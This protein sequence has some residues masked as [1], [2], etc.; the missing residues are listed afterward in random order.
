M[1]ETDLNLRRFA[2]KQLALQAPDGVLADLNWDELHDLE[3]SL[4]N[5]VKAVQARKSLFLETTDFDLIVKAES[6][7]KLNIMSVNLDTSKGGSV[8]GSPD[9]KLRALWDSVVLKKTSIVL[10]QE[11]PGHKEFRNAFNRISPREKADAIVPL[12]SLPFRIA[13]GFVAVCDFQL[14]CFGKGLSI[15]YDRKVLLFKN[16]S[17]ASVEE[18]DGHRFVYAKFELNFRSTSHVFES[19]SVGIEVINVHLKSGVK[20]TKNK[21]ISKLVTKFAHHDDARIICGDFNYLSSDLRKCP[22][23]NFSL[24]HDVDLY[25]SGSHVLDNAL[26]SLGS[27]F[28][29]I[30]SYQ[31]IDDLVLKP[32][33]VKLPKSDHLPMVFS[34]KFSKKWH[35]SSCAKL[36]GKKCAGSDF[37]HVCC[38]KCLTKCACGR[39]EVCK[40]C[41]NEKVSRKSWKLCSPCQKIG[42]KYSY[43]CD[44]NSGNCAWGSEP[45]MCHGCVSYRDMYSDDR[46]EHS[47]EDRAAKKSK[48]SDNDQPKK[49]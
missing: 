19:K 21:I 46:G 25:D 47:P 4:R 26:L 36:G 10:I 35:C 45:N 43:L 31:S 29:Q 8:D 49:E 37:E 15:L 13:D 7:G 33:I 3:C 16:E 12:Q 30:P 20:N 18:E 42:R 11:S 39:S 17:T 48:P 14:K 22:L 28:Y 40:Q 41:A 5:S 6:S 34:L 9:A 27:H 23:G 32:G 24:L 1:D 44:V 38:K 2:L